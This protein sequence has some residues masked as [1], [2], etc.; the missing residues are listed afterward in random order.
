[1]RTDGRR[2]TLKY[3]LLAAG[4]V[5]AAVGLWQFES[6]RPAPADLIKAG[7]AVRD[8]VEQALDTAAAGL[9]P[10]ASAA[11][12]LP[13]LRSA[14]KMGADRTTFQDLLE[15]EEWWIPYRAGYALSAV[16]T[17]RGVV[18][19]LG[20]R[21]A[22]AT[23]IDMLKQARAAGTAAGVVRAADGRAF[24]GAAARL[25]AGKDNNAAA[26]TADAPVVLLGAP[27]DQAILARVAGQAGDLVG[28]S[29]GKSLVG[30]TGPPA[31]RGL[32]ESLVGHEGN[33]P[34]MLA[35]GRIGVAW[36]L[37]ERQ[38]LLGVSPPVPPPAREW[39]GLLL[40]LVGAAL[41][42]FALVV[43]RAPRRRA[44]QPSPS[45]R[46]DEIP[47]P[48]S[49]MNPKAPVP[50]PTV[51]RPAGSRP[52]SGTQLLPSQLATTRPVD[53]TGRAV[54]ASPSASAVAV[55]P[56]P[57]ATGGL[58]EMGRY[59]LIERIGEGGMAEIFFAAAYGAEDFVRHFV[60][61]RMHAHLSR[62]RDVVN[63]FIDEARLQAGL[64]HSNIVPVF[65]FGKAGEE[66][67]LALEYIHGRDLGK[68]LQQHL[69]L[70]GT[71]LSV[72]ISFYVVHDVLEALA[73][74][75]SQTDKDGKPL[76]IVHRD[77]APGNILI[78]YRGEVKLTDF[79][80]AKA[81]RRVS[82]TEVG[83]VKGNACFMSPEQARGE[84]VDVRS[85]I[86]SAGLV[87]YY[88]LTGQFL[89]GGETTIN[90]LMRAAVGPATSQFNQIEELPA[91]AAAI[92]QRALANDP[93]QRYQ[94][95]EEF[96]RELGPNIGNR[97]DMAELM[98]RLFPA[99]QRRDLRSGPETD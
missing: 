85:D 22:E 5:M 1:M 48:P 37:G 79:G 59:R 42:V 38:W 56:A 41:A 25:P 57:D 86:F 62:Q 33:G 27:L 94:S 6:S 3:T 90:R 54:S 45:A 82:R 61:K 93:A 66:Y 31:T 14:W 8:R 20:A 97:R 13:E 55:A 76:D 40:A 49:G 92:L 70:V 65:D 34:M 35:E 91:A 9:V 75:H 10:A 95:A 74:A 73:F 53:I 19:A 69:E 78:S 16:I 51:P 50:V 24:L 84:S 68:I 15:N 81:E 89:Y 64:V 52:V 29:D 43:V 30:V 99:G 67:F 96:K 87:L 23:A 12:A 4:L 98:D 83:M 44:A 2:A 77:V 46:G 17:D 72:P 58:T 11:A 26:A 88:C 32:V 7:A 63:Q 39:G 28:L 21:P 60:V 36:P 47:T 18:A 80:I 71:P